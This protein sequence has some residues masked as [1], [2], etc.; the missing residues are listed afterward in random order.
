VDDVD[1]R[2]VDSPCA[3]AVRSDAGAD[4]ADELTADGVGDMTAWELFRAIWASATKA[5][6]SR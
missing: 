1:L 3:L 2:H 5:A 4:A 6:A